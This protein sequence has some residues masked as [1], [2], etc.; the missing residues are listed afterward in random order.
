M[1]T[2]LRLCC[3]MMLTILLV[4][5][6]WKNRILVINSTQEELL[7]TLLIDKDSTSIGLF[8]NNG[9]RQFQVYQTTSKRRF[10]QVQRDEPTSWKRK[11][12]PRDTIKGMLYPGTALELGVI[13][14]GSEFIDDNIVS[15]FNINYLEITGS[16][17]I[18]RYTGQAVRQAFIYS[19]K[20]YRLHFAN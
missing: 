2:K 17:G 14:G 1:K 8:D 19:D 10:I 18:V 7:I 6:S 13:N 9:Q 4:S 20:E 16:N 5:C 11:I 3:A 12:G 15:K